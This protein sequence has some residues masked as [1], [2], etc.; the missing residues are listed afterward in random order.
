MTESNAPSIE[1]TPTAIWNPNAA[2]NWSLIFTPAFGSYLHML[3]WRSLGE[4]DRAAASQK[5]FYIGIGML[6]LYVFLALLISDEKAADAATRGLGFIFLLSWYFGS[7]RAQAKYV[8]AKLGTTYVRRPW[9]KALGLAVAALFGYFVASLIFGLLVGA[10]R[11][12]VGTWLRATQT[13]S[14]S[15]LPVGG[16]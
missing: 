9:G 15:L 3:N 13:M 10:V 2:A 1:S 11:N 14:V 12:A 16:N 8:K 7:A 6:V 5:W 4:T